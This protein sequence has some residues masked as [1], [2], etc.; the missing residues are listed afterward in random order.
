MQDWGPPARVISYAQHPLDEILGHEAH[1]P[2]DSTRK[3][4]KAPTPKRQAEL[5][6]LTLRQTKYRVFHGIRPG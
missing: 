6:N 5:G 1:Q 3:M 4:M 2:S